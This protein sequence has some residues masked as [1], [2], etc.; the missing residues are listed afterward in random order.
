V[1]AFL[2]ICQPPFIMD[3][4]PFLR[5]AATGKTKEQK[6]NAGADD[7]AEEGAEIMMTNHMRPHLKT[8]K[9]RAGGYQVVRQRILAVR[10]P[11]FASLV[12]CRSGTEL[13]GEK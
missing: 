8:G 10:L 2:G 4:F 9:K 11:G 1:L 13:H 5:I 7:G 6:E 3:H 12:L